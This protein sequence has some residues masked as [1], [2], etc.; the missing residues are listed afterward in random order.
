[1]H[2][3][4][5]CAYEQNETVFTVNCGSVRGRVLSSAVAA[6]ASVVAAA[7]GRP[8][9]PIITP[10]VLMAFRCLPR[11]AILLAKQRVVQKMLLNQ[12]ARR[13]PARVRSMYRASVY[14]YNVHIEV[15]AIFHGSVLATLHSSVTRRMLCIVCACSNG[16]IL[17]FIHVINRQT[18]ECGRYASAPFGLVVWHMT[19]RPSLD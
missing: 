11:I 15:S 3:L 18:M 12:R 4:C 6:A 8:A 9:R 10:A 17:T 19:P 14:Y 16:F 7:L 13:R 2:M 5:R 1:M